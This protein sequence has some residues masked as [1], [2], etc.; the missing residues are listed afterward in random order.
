M[1]T[2]VGLLI[3]GDLYVDL[4]SHSG[5]AGRGGKEAEL[6]GTLATILSKE[7][8]TAD[9]FAATPVGSG[10]S[11]HGA[12]AARDSGARAGGAAS[13]AHATIRSAPTVLAPARCDVF[14]SY[15]WA[16]SALALGSGQTTTLHGHELADPRALSAALIASGL[17]TWLDVDALGG[18][19]GLFEEIAAGVQAAR[20]VLVCASAEYAASDNCRM[21]LQYALKVRAQCR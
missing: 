13:S 17:T 1:S 14:V 5:H 6:L 8:G 2:L 4:R 12:S 11:D 10:G 9:G 21:E 16:N 18:G 19:S 20:V 7:G 3:A 15:C